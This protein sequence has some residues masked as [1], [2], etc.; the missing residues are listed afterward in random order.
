MT[1]RNGSAAASFRPAAAGA[2]LAAVLVL[3]TGDLLLAATPTGGRP[4]T[5]PSRPRAAM[6]ITT[7]MLDQ[8]EALPGDLGPLPPAPAPADNPPTDAKVELGR[9]LYFDRRLSG[10][11][12]LSCSSC[13]D[14]RKGYADGRPRAIGFGGKELGRHSPTVL[15]AAYNG[16]Q[17]WDGRAATL[18]EQAAGPIEAPGEMNLPREELARRLGDIPEYRRRF[19]EVFGEEPGLAN[20][21]KAIAAFER[22]L[23]TPDSRFD[24]YARGDK[25]ALTEREKRGLLLFI[26]KAACSECHS[27]PNLSDSKFYV[28]GVRQ[29]GPLADDVGRY[30]VTK[31]ERDLRAFKTPTLRNV[32]LTAPYMHDGSLATLEEVV[33]LYDR[34]GGPA[35]NRSAKLLPLRLTPREKRDLV[36]FLKA[37]TGT[38]PAAAVPRL[39]PDEPDD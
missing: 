23:V 15:N 1:T 10:D 30:A 6:R 17:F 27:G 2:C 3:A 26:G 19:R 5:P 24:A 25:Q 21:A 13:H 22:T 7:A 36:A 33:E 32:A 11:G 28:L 37:L 14:P 34:G 4:G 12:S 9:L 39:P 8:L 38:P 35:P 29:R 20:V 18:E 16:A 31:D